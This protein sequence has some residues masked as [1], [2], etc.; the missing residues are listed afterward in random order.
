MRAWPLCGGCIACRIIVVGRPREIMPGS[1]CTPDLK[2]YVRKYFDRKDIGL[3]LGAAVRQVTPHGAVLESGELLAADLV[4]WCAGAERSAV[5]GVA[6]KKPFQVNAFLQSDKYPEVFATGDFA[7]VP[8]DREGANSFSAQRA[9]YQAR[10]VAGNVYR[11][12][13]HEHLQRAV[14]RAQGEVVG[15]G[16]FDGVGMLAGVPVKGKAAAAFK[17]ANEA[18]YLAVLFQDVPA[19]LLKG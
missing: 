13:S 2:A 19:S 8:D 3:R 6:S 9:L 16:D 10:A 14:Y 4:M 12:D 15:L 17:K 1:T 7:T 5:G 18:R 11:F